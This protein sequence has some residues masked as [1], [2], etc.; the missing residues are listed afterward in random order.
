MVF[1]LERLRVWVPVL[2]VLACSAAFWPAYDRYEAIGPSF[3]EAPTLSSAKIV[4]GHASETNGTFSLR[5]SGGKS[6]IVEFALPGAER[7]RLLRVCGRLETTDVKVGRFSWSMA[8][9]VLVQRNA[10]NRWISGS[11]VTKALEGTQKS[12]RYCR[13]FEVRPE[14]AGLSLA[15]QH[16]GSTGQARFSALSVVPVRI[17]PSFGWWRGVFAMAWVATAAFYVRLACRRRLWWLILPNAALIVFGVL[18]PGDW[19][20]DGAE[21]AKREVVSAVERTSSARCRAPSNSV[22][23]RPEGE[24][25][26]KGKRRDP[27]AERA[28]EQMNR[29]EKEVGG[30]HVV[31]HFALFASL[32]A[33][34]LLSLRPARRGIP[35]VVAT[36]VG[37]ILFAVST[38]L[39]QYLTMDRTPG[40]RDAAIDV[41]GMALGIVFAGLWLASDRLFRKGRAMIPLEREGK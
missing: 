38:E 4:R 27:A 21:Y 20:K 23:G 28:I 17:R 37:L 40:V 30:A 9:L 18:M 26:P 2:V 39:L 32:G 41:G 15:L 22:S 34:A 12:R 25:A 19:V 36:L 6:S 35:G 14:A 5:V 3:I 24:V 8:R 13:E 1:S 7:Q 16:L 31:G 11:H 33:L 29:F 10:K